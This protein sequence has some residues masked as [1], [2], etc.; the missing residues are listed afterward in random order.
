MGRRILVLTR[1]YYKISQT[2]ILLKWLNEHKIGWARP[3]AEVE[4]ARDVWMGVPYSY[5]Q[6]IYKI[7]MHKQMSVFY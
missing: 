3:H 2:I 6:Y 5:I 4:F 7:F 1:N